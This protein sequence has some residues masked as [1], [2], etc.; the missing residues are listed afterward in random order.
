MSCLPEYVYSVYVDG[1]LPPDEVRR[2]E[3]HLVQCQRCRRSIV[4]LQEEGGL[5]RDVFQE[6]VR[7]PAAVAPTH[8]RARGL[9]V[10]IGPALVIALLAYS[11]VGWVLDQRLP[12]GMSWLNPL[13]FFGAYDMLFDF[14]F[15]A[16][17]RAPALFDLGIAVGATAGF[18]GLLTFI[19][20]A[21][22]RRVAGV[23]TLALLV[24]TL[25]AGA[26][27]PGR[28]LDLRFEQQH[29]TVQASETVS[30]TLAASAESIV[31]DGVVDGDLLAL[32]ESI[33]IRGK[34][35]GNVIAGGR[36]V[37]VTGQVDG[38]L[39][40]V[41]GVC[42]IEGEVTGNLYGAGERVNVRDSARI[43]RDAF[44]FGDNVQMD[45]SAGRD[46]W[47]GASSFELHGSV[48]RD[49]ASH[50]ERINVFE[51]ASIGG[52]L[53]VK[54]SP[55]GS[56]DIASAAAIRG[57]TTQA[58][59]EHPMPHPKN[60]LSDPGFYMRVLVFI[61][62]AFLVGMVLHAVFPRLFGA[63]LDTAGDFGRCLGFGFAALIATPLVLLLCVLTV[64]G[65]P[66][67][68]IGLFVYVTMLFVSLIVIA[69]LVGSALTGAEPTSTHGFGTA[70]L[71][72]LVIV[73]VAMNLPFLGA[74]L[75]LLVGLAG[76]GLLV[77]TAID[78][79]RERR[80]EFA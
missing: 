42:S 75:R 50:T 69:A 17:D 78:T 70:L 63:R 11:A 15:I 16:R 59:V 37:V 47:T 6:R 21:L 30:E 60:R 5:L 57:E 71:L 46:L 52:D 55:N 34:V 22:L 72:G 25:V 26:P 2:V 39:H 49:V 28:A 32:A 40:V 7:A 56:V 33:D 44:L 58:E 68:V 3:A 62:S 79:W 13:S 18:A 41:C 12:Q 66:I 10:G 23:G 31:I 73:A 38:S 8:A 53:D 54:T 43:G 29:V 76:M 1:E 67:G 51:T 64:V 77:V 65:I 61:A 48:A 74:P 36:E 14:V 27:A 80:A 4:A 24:T 9:V 35:R 19:G 45:G 20:T